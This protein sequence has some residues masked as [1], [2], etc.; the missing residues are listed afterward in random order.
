MLNRLNH[1]VF[2]L[3][4][5]T[6]V[7]VTGALYGQENVP[8]P[9]ADAFDH[10]IERFNMERIISSPGELSNPIGTTNATKTNALPARDSVAVKLPA[11]KTNKPAADAA[12]PVKPKGAEDDILS[13]NFLYYI[14]QKYKL[15]DIID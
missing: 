7:L 10:E 5:L 3:S 14:I 11:Q 15:Q 4:A 12:K 2:C 6:C 1:I 9:H 13:F 8:A